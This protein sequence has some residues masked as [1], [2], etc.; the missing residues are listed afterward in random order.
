MPVVHVSLLCLWSPPVAHTF[1]PQKPPTP[2][3]SSGSTTSFFE[4][5]TWLCC[6]YLQAA[7]H[8]VFSDLLLD[9]APGCLHPSHTC[10]EALSLAGE[11]QV[12]PNKAQVHFQAA[13]SKQLAIPD[14]LGFS[15][16][17][18]C[19][20]LTW[21]PQ[22]NFLSQQ[23]GLWEDKEVHSLT[24]SV[25]WVTQVVVTGESSES[26]LECF[27][28]EHSEGKPFDKL[29]FTFCVNTESQLMTLRGV[30]GRG[31]LGAQ[32][33]GL[34]LNWDD[35]H[36]RSRSCQIITSLKNNIFYMTF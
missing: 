17:L 15:D 21:M 7:L 29:F 13:V 8:Q 30:E 16:L 4:N 6:L 19:S 26:H 18:P 35:S 25:G 23:I 1:Y 2:S 36:Y 5:K 33:S 12:S 24:Y 34:L 10:A 32:F 28:N 20:F 3:L 31:R 14:G 11:W 9:Q 27:L 22:G